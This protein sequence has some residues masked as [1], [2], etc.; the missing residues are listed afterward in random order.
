M[1]IGRFDVDDSETDDLRNKE[2]TFHRKLT[3]MQQPVRGMTQP[4]APMMAPPNFSPPI[5]AWQNGARGIS[6]CIN[7]NTYIWLLGGNS[8]WFFPT[9]VGRQ[10]VIGF[11]F[12]GFGWI[13]QRI[14]LNNIRSF[15]C[16]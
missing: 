10:A 16:F 1:S 14:Y 12:R 7:R 2:S 5:P 4:P 9:F 11:R 3:T 6:G 8:F 15:Q 13:Y